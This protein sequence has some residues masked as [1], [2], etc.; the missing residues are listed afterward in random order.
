[1]GMLRWAETVIVSDKTTAKSQS[2]ACFGETNV[3]IY[4]LWDDHPVTSFEKLD[5]ISQLR[6]RG[7]QLS[8][9]E[10]IRT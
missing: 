3:P 8:W 7:T 6:A 2:S 1:M 10:V 5:T 4:Y 9:M